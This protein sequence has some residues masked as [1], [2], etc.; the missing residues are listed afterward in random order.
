MG[1]TGCSKK[2]KG[3]AEKIWDKNKKIILFTS[4]NF[5]HFSG[6][7]IAKWALAE[8]CHYNNNILIIKNIKLL[9]YKVQ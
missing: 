7:R 2:R 9:L 8:L 6:L 4:K 3:G 1:G 5:Y